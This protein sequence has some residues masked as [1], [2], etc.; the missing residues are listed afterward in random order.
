[1]QNFMIEI[2]D[3]LMQENAR[4]KSGSAAMDK[5]GETA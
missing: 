4:K 5:N 3:H 2:R 1:M